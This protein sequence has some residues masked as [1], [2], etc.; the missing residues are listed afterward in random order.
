[1][2]QL[3]I[4]ATPK[5]TAA[6]N[7]RAH[8]C[9][10]ASELKKGA[11]TQ[12]AKLTIIKGRYRRSAKKERACHS[13]PL[14]Y[15]AKPCHTSTEAIPKTNNQRE[16]DRIADETVICAIS[17]NDTGQRSE[18]AADDVRFVSERIGWLRFAGPS[19]WP[20]SKSL[21]SCC[22]IMPP[23]IRRKRRGTEDCPV[24]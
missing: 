17:S 21:N 20:L 23:T 3:A 9:P 6:S 16:R 1:M 11:A 24:R 14:Q 7:A 12:M 4:K 18:P 10:I 5:A 22:A 19:G 8:R 2:N 13:S 15:A